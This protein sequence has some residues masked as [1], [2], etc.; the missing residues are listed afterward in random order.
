MAQ[1]MDVMARLREEADGCYSWSNAPGDVYAEH[2]HSYE[3]VLYCVAGSIT[4]TL[5]DR[6]LRLRTGDRMVLPP[7][8]V[9]GAVVGP[10]GCTCIEGRGR[11]MAAR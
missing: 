10:D 8:T 3:K 9:H 6:K 1:R 2:S 4:F 7:G 11:N 5:R